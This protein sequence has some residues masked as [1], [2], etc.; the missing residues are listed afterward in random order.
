[1]KDYLYGGRE[2][3]DD[4]CVLEKPLDQSK[5][6]PPYLTPAAT[7]SPSSYLTPE[8]NPS[9]VSQF[10]TTMSRLLAKPVLAASQTRKFDP[11]EFKLG[12]STKSEVIN[13]LGD[14]LQTGEDSGLTA[15][16]FASSGIDQPNVFIFDQNNLLIYFRLNQTTLPTDLSLLKSWIPK[17]GDP[18]V[19]ASSNF[20]TQSTRL[21]FP[22]QGFTLV[23]DNQTD[24]VLQY[25]GFF[26]TNISEY[27][28]TWGKDI[29]PSELH[30]PKP[31][32]TFIEK[33]KNWFLSI[34]SFL[35]AKMWFLTKMIREF[36]V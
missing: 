14:P 1:M 12:I 32:Q 19:I 16:A 34:W 26:P 28:Q 33:V 13:L 35:Q 9:F 4:N 29:Y 8:V 20:K 10:Q 11:K 30:F 25:E 18:E 23:V 36:R 17:Y 21:F 7:S 3:V 31:K 2:F 22:K 24:Q 27:L 15:L 6:T 5:T